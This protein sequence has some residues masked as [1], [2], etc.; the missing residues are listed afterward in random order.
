MD[1]LGEKEAGLAKTEHG[2]Y[3]RQMN[4]RDLIFIEDNNLIK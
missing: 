3:K 1:F 2:L 4:T